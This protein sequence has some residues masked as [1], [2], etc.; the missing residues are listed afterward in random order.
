MNYKLTLDRME[1]LSGQIGLV[2]NRIAEL[3]NSKTELK[4]SV[5]LAISQSDQPGADS[6]IAGTIDRINEIDVELKKQSF[7]LDSLSSELK[8]LPVENAQKMQQFETLYDEFKKNIS[9]LDRF[10]E[11]WNAEVEVLESMAKKS[12]PNFVRFLHLYDV[13]GRLGRELK[14]TPDL[15]N[16]ELVRYS[17]W[18]AIDTDSDCPFR[19]W[20]LF[21]KIPGNGKGRWLNRRMRNGQL[22]ETEN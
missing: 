9:G 20:R 14:N 6:E 21:S 4:T 19:L 3:V 11:K 12:Y 13:L 10:A 17:H 1:K 8:K 18:G 16:P 5:D 15:C 22:I 2:Q 7:I